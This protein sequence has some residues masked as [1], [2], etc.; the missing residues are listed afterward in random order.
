MKE[1]YQEMRYTVGKDSSII[2]HTIE[3]I[4]ST[5]NIEIT[6]YFLKNNRELKINLDDRILEDSQITARGSKKSLEELSKSIKL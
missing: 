2:N 1:K 4:Q 6:H 3:N 5:Y